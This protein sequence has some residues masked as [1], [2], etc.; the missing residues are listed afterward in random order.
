MSDVGMAAPKLQ[1]FESLMLKDLS[2]S[3]SYSSFFLR[4]HM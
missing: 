3:S 1:G 4:I 2:S